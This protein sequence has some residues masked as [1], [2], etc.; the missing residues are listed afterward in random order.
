VTRQTIYNIL[1]RVHC[2]S[3]GLIHKA[4]EKWG[5]KFEFRGL[6]VERDAIRPTPAKLPEPERESQ[7]NLDLREALQK[8][9][10]RSIDVIEAKPM[11]RSIEIVLR[12]KIPA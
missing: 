11:E 3:L 10:Y 6:L 1:N 2:P 12:L 7:M 9:D 4:C 5:L 8:I